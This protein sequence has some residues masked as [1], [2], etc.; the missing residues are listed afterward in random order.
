[1]L[2]YNAIFQKATEI[3]LQ[4]GD[5]A[6]GVRYRVGGELQQAD[7]LPRPDGDEVV[8]LLQ[9]LAD[10]SESGRGRVTAEADGRLIDLNVTASGRGA[11]AIR[12]L[13]RARKVPDLD[14]LGLLKDHVEQ[15]S[16]LIARPRGLLLFGSP[17][18]SGRTTTLCSCLA[19]VPRMQKRVVF[20]T[21]QVEL[22]VPNTALIELGGDPPKDS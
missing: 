16:E 2:V 6:I 12:L 21:E 1:V 19:A 14:Q 10:I 4:P 11:M 15:L 17:A 22:A 13:D 7:P 20:L 8:G 18:G 5:A 3:V 9:A